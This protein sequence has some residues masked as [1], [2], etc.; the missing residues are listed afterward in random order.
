MEIIYKNSHPLQLWQYY[1]L[2]MVLITSHLPIAESR[3]FNKEIKDHNAVLWKQN[4][5][6]ALNFALIIL[7]TISNNMEDSLNSIFKPKCSYGANFVFNLVYMKINPKP[8]PH[9]I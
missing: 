8:I 1:I 9:K 3:H 5:L 4:V 7:F 6:F 2:N